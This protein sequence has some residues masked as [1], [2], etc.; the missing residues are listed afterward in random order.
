MKSLRII[1]VFLLL[2]AASACKKALDVN[3]DPASPQ[4][5]KPEYLL[6]PMIAQMAIN[7]AFDYR[8][9]Q[10]NL[11]QNMGAQTENNAFERHGFSASD[12]GGALW[13]MVY[14]SFGLNLEEMITNGE[15]A[16]ANTLVGIGLA[17]KAWGYQL[18]TDSH[19]PV[20]LDEAFKDQLKF[21]YQDQ[22][23][24]YAKVRLWCQQALVAL[25]KP[26]VGDYSNFL[27]NADQLFG[28]DKAKWRKFIYAVLA[29]QYSHLTS[30][31]DFKTRY[32]DSVVKYVDLSFAAASEDPTI[33]FA[34]NFPYS[35]TT[36]PGDANPLS[37]FAGIFGAAG[38]GRIGQP[39]VNY[40]C[41]GVRGTPTVDPKSSTDPRLTRMINPMVTT[42]TATNGVYRGVVATRGDLPT[43]KTIPH[44]FGIATATAQALFPGKYLFGQGAAANDKPRFPL[45]S[46]SQ[47]Q[48]AKSEALFLKGDKAGALTSYTNGIRGHMD[49]V[50]LYGRN[51]LVQAPA[52]TPAEITAYMASNEVV[53][54]AGD[55]TLADIMGQKYI[56]QWGWAGQ[57]QWCDLRKHHYSPDVFRQFKQLESSEFFPSTPGKYA[58]RIRP[59]YNSE[60]IFNIAEIRK[61]GADK[62]EYTTLETWFSLPD[63]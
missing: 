18:L 6:A 43:T 25:N 3:T 40:L 50:N 2:I 35:S 48:F 5:T 38:S 56:A 47:L 7:P 27:R 37:V 28:G 54:T 24:V 14:I 46:Y 15:A 4:K 60:Y 8:D 49:F 9:A 53:K 17:M 45:F 44:V 39:I 41:G 51:G 52:I 21:A 20:I 36:A 26:D 22:P 58:Y 19:G 42:S 13:R 12:T 33:G 1:Y 34:G 16:G 23:E 11:T 31:N 30:K 59:R 29:T 55:L 10:F 32:A 61:W 62:N 57:E 63:Q